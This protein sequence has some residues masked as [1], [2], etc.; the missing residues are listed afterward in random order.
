VKQQ[1][2]GEIMERD[3]TIDLIINRLNAIKGLRDLQEMYEGQ[4]EEEKA[5]WAEKAL[6]DDAMALMPELQKE[7]GIELVH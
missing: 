4:L 5:N 1:N 6:V 7:A 2:K 3:K